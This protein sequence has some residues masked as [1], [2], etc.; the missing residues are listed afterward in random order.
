M[1]HQSAGPRYQGLVGT[2]YRELSRMV[3]DPAYGHAGTARVLT[4]ALK[5]K[6]VDPREFHIRPLFEALVPKGR[7][8]LS[9]WNSGGLSS[10]AAHLL[11]AGAVKS[12]QFSN[13]TGQIVYSETLKY[14]EDEEFVFSKEV[15]E[16]PSQFIDMEKIAGIARI[17]D[18]AEVVGEAQP[19]PYVGP[20]ED[21]IHAPYAEKRGDICALSWE[22]VFSDRTGD[23]LGRAGELGH[24]LGLNREKR[25]IDM[26]VDENGGAKSAA[27]GGHRYHWRGTS[28]ATYDTGT[29]WDNVTTSN[30]LVD[31]TDVEAAE[32][33]LS[34]IVDP[35]TGE[36]I[37]VQPDVIVVTKQLEYTARY[38]VTSTSL[39]VNAGGYNAS[40]TVTRFEL[41][42]FLPKYKVLTSRLLETR[43]ATDTDWFLGNLKK[44]FRY[45]VVRPLQVEQAPDSHPDNFN[46]D[47][48]NQ[49]KVSEFGNAFTFDPR[50]INES[51]A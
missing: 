26:V 37:L 23:L 9:D 11:E 45:K 17:G 20:G 42:N 36:P 6:D 50:F 22:A 44:A 16:M 41:P 48:V 2:S 7:E 35:N 4:E 5:R 25:I 49:W 29:T 46:R 3:A 30:A 28:Y 31:W 10:G 18:L 1:A 39:A 34:R 15:P 47:I 32:L 38:V 13:I 14:Y 12:S 24:W 33:T 43:M 40:S 21:Y 51:R 8:F 19:Y 27:L